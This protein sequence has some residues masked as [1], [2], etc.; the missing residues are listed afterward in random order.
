MSA[1]EHNFPSPY[2][3]ANSTSPW[4]ALATAVFNDFVNR[5]NTA[6]CNGGLKWQIF[7]SNV[8][9]DYKNT[10]ANGGFFQLSARLARH[11]GNATYLSWAEKTW[12]WM[13]RIQLVDANYRV[14]DGTQDGGNCTQVNHA[15]FS[16]TTGM[17]LYGS[18]VLANYTNGS[19]VWME[20]TEGL[21]GATTPF[22]TPFPNASLIMYE[23][24][25]EPQGTCDTDQL[26]FKGLLARWMAA[27][28]Q[29]VPDIS[30]ATMSLLQASAQAAAMACSGGPSNSTCGQKWYVGGFD[31][32]TGVGQQLS[33][34]EVVQ[35]LL[36]NTTTPPNAAANVHI[37]VATATTTVPVPTVTPPPASIGGD[38]GGNAISAATGGSGLTWS[39]L[40]MLL[41]TGLGFII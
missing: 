39:Q 10:A 18:A 34:L 12:D 37:S 23:S 13:S 40:R 20:R 36:T 7:P 28:A 31:G 15:T 3:S 30:N 2:E 27:S 22:F 33:A 25:C 16:Y 6:T 11:T 14:W 32:S 29:L 8:G 41:I 21:L 5:W 26:S 4:L 35:G 38:G 19:S 1:A 24:E 9:Y 17:L